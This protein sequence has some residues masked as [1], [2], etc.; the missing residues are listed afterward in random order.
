MIDHQIHH[1][2][3]ISGDGTDILPAAPV[4]ID[5]TV[6]NYRKT[7]VRTVGK[8]RQDMHIINRVLQMSA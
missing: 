7:I 4:G 8:K 6:I 2:I 1:Q 3:K 5:L